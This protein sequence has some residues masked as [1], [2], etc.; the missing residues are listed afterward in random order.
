MNIHTIADI[1]LYG[2]NAIS[3][4]C[5]IRDRKQ[6]ARDD[7]LIQDLHEGL[8]AAHRTANYWWAKGLVLDT[9]KRKQDDALRANLA[10]ANGK[11]SVDNA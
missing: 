2:A 11:R 6:K 5:V 1:A 9:A 3:V 8:S 7:K 4:V 10:K